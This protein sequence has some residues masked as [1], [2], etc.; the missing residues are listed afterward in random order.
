MRR[1]AAFVLALAAA[2]GPSAAARRAQSLYDQGDY[3]GAARSADADLAAHPGDAALHRVA[4][5]A[6]LAGGDARGAVDGYLA[7]RNG[8]DDD[9]VALR[10]L[11]ETTFQQALRSPSN[12]TKVQAIEAIEE[13]EIEALADDVMQRLGDEDDQVQAAAAVA[14]LHAHPQ[15]PEILAAMLTSDDPAARAIAVRGMAEKIGV[16]A[17]DDLRNATRDPDPRVR[18]AAIGGLAPLDDGE[19][20]DVLVQLAQKDPDDGV[21]AAAL[22]ALA[23][24]KRGDQR[25]VASAAL[26]DTSLAVR[27]AAVDVIAASGDAAAIHGLL[28]NPD[29]LIAAQAARAAAKT[30][31]AGAAAAIDRA[32]AD[33]APETRAAA[34]NLAVAALGKP[35]AAERAARASADAAV[36]VRLAAARVLAS[37]GHAD[38]AAPIFAAVLASGSPDDQIQAAADLARQGDARGVS[39][40]AEL[41]RSADSVPRRRAAALAHL[42]ARRI[43]PGLVTALADPAPE[44]RVDAA[45]VLWSLVHAGDLAEQHAD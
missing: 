2:C 43:T 30:D 22:H 21:R 36:P 28:A 27:L 41:A 11:A 16:H 25:A 39:S 38:Q 5:R 20:T 19:T 37:T 9:R 24:G 32:L 13:L 14:V 8:Q 34:L 33:P 18:R 3:Q 26:G 35:A 44:V 4:L 29:P 23:R 17:E 31:P 7:W 10:L 12:A 1:F 42:T 6:R 40:L 15:A 45:R